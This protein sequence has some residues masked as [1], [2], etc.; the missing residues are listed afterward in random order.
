MNVTMGD[1]NKVTVVH[2]ATTPVMGIENTN[3]DIHPDSSSIVGETWFEKY[4]D[5]LLGI[6]FLVIAYV[7]ARRMYLTSKQSTQRPPSQQQQQQSNTTTTPLQQANGS[8]RQGSNNASGGAETTVVT[9]FYSLI[10]ATAILRS[11]WFLVPVIIVLLNDELSLSD[12]NIIQYT[13]VAIYAWD[14]TINKYSWI[15]Y[16]INELIVTSGSLTLFSIF[17]L[18]LVY[19]AD[20][21]K[22]YYNPGSRRSLPMITFL[23]LVSSLVVLEIINILLFLCKFYSS[24][25][26]ILFNAILLA[27]VS[28]ICVCEI[29]IF[30]RKFQNVLKTLGAINQVSTDSQIRR[31]VWITVTGNVFFLSRAILETIFAV[32]LLIHYIQYHTI[33]RFFTHTWWDI[34]TI[35]KYTC[36]IIILI[37]M[38]H[39]LQSR[40]SQQQ[41]QSQN[42][43]SSTPTGAQPSQNNTVGY[44][45]VPDAAVN[46]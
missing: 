6:A 1:D 38:L 5:I 4:S 39:I 14:N 13:P 19:W 46:V 7:A 18:I 27:I 32:M 42:R 30:S 9:A 29:T 33:N 44:S 2:A 25:G 43:T 23:G 21:L 41:S 26:M 3:D 8:G 37:L 12:T 17:I 22:K 16:A 36:E 28:I 11:I 45:K 15:G 34:Y 10:L 31:I 24:E 35:I 40:F 20:I